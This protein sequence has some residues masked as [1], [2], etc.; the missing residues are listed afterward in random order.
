M[1][2]ELQHRS[3]D[4]KQQL[5][6]CGDSALEWKLIS[7]DCCD[8]LLEVVVDE[9]HLIYKCKTHLVN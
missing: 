5:Y 4:Y 7:L 1:M 2:T 3:L 8:N 6:H 9:V